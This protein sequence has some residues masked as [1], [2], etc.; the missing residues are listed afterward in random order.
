MHYFW[1]CGAFEIWAGFVLDPLPVRAKSR[2]VVLGNYEDCAWTKSE[3]FAP[4]LRADSLRY[5][6]S[7]AVHKR[8]LLKQGDCKNAFCNGD[9]PDDEVTI[10]RPPSGDPSAT[11]GD[12]WLLKKILH[13]LCRSPRH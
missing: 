2:K 4:L 6:V 10:V 9:L 1:V 12:F 5:I 11:K 8:R 13:G 3:K 7:L